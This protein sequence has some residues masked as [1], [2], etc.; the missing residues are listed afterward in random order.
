MLYN[1][2]KEEVKRLRNSHVLPDFPNAEMLIASIQTE[3]DTVKA[4]LP[5]P[6][7]P[8][9]TPKA[10]VFVAHYPETNFGCVYREGAL[11]LQCT[12]RNEIGFYCLSMP[13]DDDMAMIGGRESFGFPKKIAEKITL[14]KK[15][16]HITGSVE[17]K[18]TEIIR[19]EGV[20]NEQSEANLDK[21]F[22]ASMTDWNGEVCKRVVNFLFKYF[23]SPGGSSFDYLPRLIREPVL[24]R[25]TGKIM[26]GEGEVKLSSTP[27][28][29]LGEIPVKVVDS[30]FYGKWHNTM[31]PGKAVA[32]AWNP[33]KFVKHSFF[34][35]DFAP[36]FLANYDEDRIKKAKEIL[37]AAKKF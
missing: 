29:P 27:Y 34:K 28:D 32:R 31:L 23:P 14:E 6:L 13:V 36:T 12:F 11:L 2:S 18:G 15:G 37:H 7:A 33:L 26:V 3:T 10:I 5:N 25:K 30:L 1:L 19:I 4:I 16:N 8:S 22:G 20:F 35:T 24:F 21:E 17:R 9:D